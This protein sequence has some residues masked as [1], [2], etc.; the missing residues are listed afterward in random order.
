MITEGTRY[1][2]EGAD[3]RIAAF[4]KGAVNT[5]T[6]NAGIAG[7]RQ[8]TTRLRRNTQSMGKQAG[9]GIVFRLNVV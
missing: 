4:G 7:N 6:V 3:T 8:H 5:R 1:F 2:I 9:I